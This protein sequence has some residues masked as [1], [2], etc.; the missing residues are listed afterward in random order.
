MACD[1]VLGVFQGNS[2]SRRFTDANL[3]SF[4]WAGSV[5]QLFVVFSLIVVYLPLGRPKQRQKPLY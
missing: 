5:E 4:L 2:L 1:F 3:K